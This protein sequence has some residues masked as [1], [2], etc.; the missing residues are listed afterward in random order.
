MTVAFVH[1]GQLH[2][3]GARMVM[4]SVAFI[5]LHESCSQQ[6][7]APAILP[8]RRLSE[9]LPTSATPFICLWRLKGALENGPTF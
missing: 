1:C 5:S 7:K 6:A 9:R 2:A 8:R 4:S 3:I